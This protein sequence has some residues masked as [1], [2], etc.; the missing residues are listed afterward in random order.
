M[1]CG[2]WR[3]IYLEYFSAR[4]CD[5]SSRVSISIDDQTAKIV[6]TAETEDTREGD[7][8]SFTMMNP[9][10]NIVEVIGPLG[11]EKNN[12]S[13]TFYLN[14]ARFWWPVGYGEH[15][16]YRISAE[17]SRKVSYIHR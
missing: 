12:A 13:A 10:G 11:V 3:P 9:D 4:I 5:L 15:P 7:V 2:P 14:N 8:I 17:L 1:T 16:L 6:V